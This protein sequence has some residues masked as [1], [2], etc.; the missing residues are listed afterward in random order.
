[1]HLLAPLPFSATMSGGE[2]RAS[3]LN[4]L[5]SLPPESLHSFVVHPAHGTALFK[6]ICEKWPPRTHSLIFKV[7]LK[8]SLW[9]LLFSCL[10]IKVIQAF[11]DLS[12]G[13]LQGLPYSEWY[14]HQIEYRTASQIV[15]LHCLLFKW[16]NVCIY[17]Y[18]KLLYFSEG[19]II[20]VS[21]LVHIQATRT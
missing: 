3:N 6:S 14:R 9:V 4:R 15:P 19:I 1:M 7:F 21:L 10:N 5:I 12:G 17:R 8:E 11:I 20:L 2:W 16:L 18:K 13:I